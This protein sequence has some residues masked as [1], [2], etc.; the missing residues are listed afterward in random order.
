MNQFKGLAVSASFLVLG[1]CAVLFPLSDMRDAVY[2][3][4]EPSALD[5][6]RDAADVQPQAGLKPIDVQGVEVQSGQESKLKGG[7]GEEGGEGD[8]VSA[9][10]PCLDIVGPLWVVSQM[11]RTRAK[12][13]LRHD[14][15]H[16]EAVRRLGDEIEKL[17]SQCRNGNLRVVKESIDAVRRSTVYLKGQPVPEGGAVNKGKADKIMDLALKQLYRFDPHL[18]PNGRRTMDPYR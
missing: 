6:L 10:D 5:S 7:G 16:L 12:S 15:Y 17:M 9:E 2:G 13:V 8:E 3:G 14:A 18:N 4:Q 11:R 1:V